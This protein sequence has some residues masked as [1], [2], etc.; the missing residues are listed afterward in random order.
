MNFWKWILSLFKSKAPVVVPPV[1]TPVPVQP[2]PVIVPPVV[3]TK[4]P[5]VVDIKVGGFPYSI[6]VVLID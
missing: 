3:D 4:T 1:K 2:V 5:E 6:P